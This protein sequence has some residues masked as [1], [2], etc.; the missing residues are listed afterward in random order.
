MPV[1]LS[2]R[3][4]THLKGRAHPL[5]PTVQVGHGGLSD[6]VVLELERALNA[7]GLIK[8]RING[9]DRESRQAIIERISARTDAAVVHT[10]GKIVVLWRPAP[11]EQA[12]GSGD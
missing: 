10:V 3:E 2:A 5:E 12:P 1:A 8:V 6:A 7:H 9:A 4:R 11:D